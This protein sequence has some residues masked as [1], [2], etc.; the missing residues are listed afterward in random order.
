MKTIQMKIDDDLLEAVDRVSRHLKTTRSA[1]IAEALRMVLQQPSITDLEHQHG[2]GYSRHPTKMDE[3]D[4]WE[5]EQ[6]WGD[7]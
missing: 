2:Q 7:K 6:V 4:G 1:V 3:F 5:T